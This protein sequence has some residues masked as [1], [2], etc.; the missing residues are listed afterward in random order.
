MYDRDDLK[1]LRDDS[2]EP[3]ASSGDSPA[4][5]SEGQLLD[6]YSRAVTGAVDLVGP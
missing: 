3:Q 2:D 4:P 6:A 1:F 5:A